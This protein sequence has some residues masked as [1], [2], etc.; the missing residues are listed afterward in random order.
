[1]YLRKNMK[2]G[3]DGSKI[4]HYQIAQNRRDPR[5]KKSKPIIIQ[6]VG[7]S[8]NPS[9]RNG[10][11]RLCLAIA[12]EHQL[13]VYDPAD[14]EFKEKVARSDDTV[15]L[16]EIKRI[17][18]EKLTW[19]TD[20]IS[21]GMVELCKSIAKTFNLQVSDSSGSSDNGLQRPVVLGYKDS[22]VP[23][24]K[25]REAA[26]DV[27]EVLGLKPRIQS[28]WSAERIA[29]SLRA[30]SDL[31][32]ADDDIKEDTFNALN[33]LV[34]FKEQIILDFKAKY[35]ND[36]N[37][38]KPTVSDNAKIDTTFTRDELLS[39]VL[40]LNKNIPSVP[41]IDMRWP[42]NDIEDCCRSIGESLVSRGPIIKY[43]YNIR[44]KY[45]DIHLEEQTW[46]VLYTLGALSPEVIDALR[47]KY[48][49]AS[50]L[51]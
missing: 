31:I 15:S 40:D 5:T 38:V 17:T 1:M 46:L 22:E 45:V 48:P 3:K 19:G 2:P 6:G 16:E 49:N 51:R 12:E 27:N 50:F 37:V 39:A 26:E 24:D 28:D 13:D 32:D 33:D 18:A 14:P 7:R 29:G 47:S 4:E 34:I 36:N 42:V 20:K 44:N 43:K 35:S 30:V 23:I 9:T 25:L 41:K 11:L 8:D 21:E 10:L